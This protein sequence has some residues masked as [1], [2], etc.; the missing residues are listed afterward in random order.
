SSR[1]AAR[2]RSPTRRRRPRQAPCPPLL[3]CPRPPAPPRPDSSGS[4]RTP[5]SRADAAAPACDEEDAAHQLTN[6]PIHQL[7]NCSFL[8]WN[9][10]LPFA[11]IRAGDDGDDRVAVA[12]VEH[13]VR[14]AGLD[15]D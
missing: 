14:H 5:R 4:S 10:V 9:D 12:G 15:E 8:V 7:T 13:F 11:R 1:T 2:R 6:S 3:L